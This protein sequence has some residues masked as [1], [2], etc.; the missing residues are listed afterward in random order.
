MKEQT[1]K[2]LCLTAALL[3]LG[4]GVIFSYLTFKGYSHIIP[5]VI[6][7][8]RKAIF[9]LLGL[10]AAAAFGFYLR[11]FNLQTVTGTLCIAFSVGWFTCK[12]LLTDFA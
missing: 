2:K 7:P 6:G 1:R 8:Y 12:M 11:P 10:L 4:A 5:I 3:F 9:I